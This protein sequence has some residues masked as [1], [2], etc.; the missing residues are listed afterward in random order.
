MANAQ[1][2]AN[3]KQWEAGK[4]GNPGGRPKDRI[5]PALVL[6][7]MRTVKR[8]KVDV[9]QAQA[10]A[11]NL[12]RLALSNRQVAVPAAKLIL[13]YID[14][15][16]TQQ[17]DVSGQIDHVQLDSARTLLRVVGGLDE[18]RTG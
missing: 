4:S 10:L 1:S 2:L 5:R 16:P 18:R 14:G 7:A 6:E 3:L 17:I 12:F 11:E 9:T 15:K 13:E 8:N